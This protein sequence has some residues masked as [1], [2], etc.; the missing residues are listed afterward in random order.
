V[1]HSFCF[2]IFSFAFGFPCGANTFRVFFYLRSN[3]TKKM[4]SATLLILIASCLIA[5]TFAAKGC[6]KRDLALR[7]SPQGKRL[8]KP[9][10]HEVLD[11]A[12]LPTEWDWRNVNGTN[13]L[14]PTRNQHIP[15][16]CGSC[17]AHVRTR[18]KKICG[19]FSR[20]FETKL[21]IGGFSNGFF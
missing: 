8:T 14:S 18:Q 10:P 16:Y 2:A 17:W 15:Q 7:S 19:F 1:S 12:Q 3:K 5:M 6:V 13:F 9:Q 20:I 11:V 4:R 21:C